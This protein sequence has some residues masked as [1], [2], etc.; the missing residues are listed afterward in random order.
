MYLKIWFCI[1]MSLWIFFI[2]KHFCA[3]KSSGPLL[4]Q[5]LFFEGKN[6]GTR[7]LISWKNEEGKTFFEA[8]KILLPSTCSHKFCTLPQQMWSKISDVR[9]MTFHDVAM[10]V[11]QSL[12]WDRSIYEGT[13]EREIRTVFFSYLFWVSKICR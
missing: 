7:T 9:S 8:K 12:S 13:Q 11:W 5:K 6:D 2:C 1:T 10:T 3:G 4:G